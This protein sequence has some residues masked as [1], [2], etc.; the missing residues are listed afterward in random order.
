MIRRHASSFPAVTLVLIDLIGFFAALNLSIWLRY[1][2]FAGHFIKQG[3]P[4]WAQITEALPLVAVCRI[5]VSAGVGSYRA[6][7][8]ALS[9]F[10]AVLRATILTFLGVLSASFLP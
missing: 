5:A 9:E 6:G 3:P 2:I 4:P 8:S 7:T 10:S 1:D